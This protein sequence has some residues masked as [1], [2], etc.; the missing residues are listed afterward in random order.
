MIV[1]GRSVGRAMIGAK[2]YDVVF[3]KDLDNFLTFRFF[4]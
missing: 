3:V 2:K 1:F 4:V